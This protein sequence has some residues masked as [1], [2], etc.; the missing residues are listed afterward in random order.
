MSKEIVSLGVVRRAGKLFD[1]FGLLDSV[2][3]STERLCEGDICCLG[4]RRKVSAL[5]SLYKLYHRVDHP[6]NEYLYHFVAARNTSG[7]GELTLV[8]PRYRSD[9]FSQSFLSDAVRL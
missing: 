5:C 8:I 9:Q 7:P 1:G 4:H 3:H 2:G 6:M